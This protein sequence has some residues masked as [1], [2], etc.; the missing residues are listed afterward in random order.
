MSDLFNEISRSALET[1]AYKFLSKFEEASEESEES[2]VVFLSSPVLDGD[3][4]ES[5]RESVYVKFRQELIIDSTDLD[6]PEWS[7]EVFMRFWGE[8]ID[9]FADHIVFAEGWEASPSCTY[10]FMTAWRLGIPMYDDECNTLTPNTAIDLLNVAVS[11]AE[12][13]GRN[14][15][16]QEEA[17]ELLVSDLVDEYVM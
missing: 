3:E 5:A 2:G 6:V 8:V 1:R 14:V 9:L 16:M 4:L 10:E 12:T 7:P 13:N 11:E 15:T 17:L